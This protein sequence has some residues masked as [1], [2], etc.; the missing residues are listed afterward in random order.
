MNLFPFVSLLS[1][2]VFFVCYK[3]KFSLLSWERMESCRLIL[4]VSF[5]VSKKVR[6]V[7]VLIRSECSGW[8]RVELS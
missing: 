2:R 1:V 6:F 7:V 5:E 4:K 3:L 8:S